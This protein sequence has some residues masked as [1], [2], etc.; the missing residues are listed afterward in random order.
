MAK[1]KTTKVVNMP[2]PQQETQKAIHPGGFASYEDMITWASKNGF[3]NAPFEVSFINGKNYFQQFDVHPD[4]LKE[5]LQVENWAD[6]KP[7]LVGNAFRCSL[8]HAKYGNLRVLSDGVCLWIGLVNLP[9]VPIPA[10][11]LNMEVDVRMMG[12]LEHIRKT[13]IIA[14]LE[15]FTVDL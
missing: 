8:A 11:I 6:I 4:K 1:Q 7:H 14:V 9:N 10:A 3:K 13:T 12:R 2:Q 5:I 15:D